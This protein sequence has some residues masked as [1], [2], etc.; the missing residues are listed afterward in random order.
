MK[1]LRSKYIF[2]NGVNEFEHYLYGIIDDSNLLTIV[3]EHGKD[4]HLVYNFRDNHGIWGALDEL[5][6]GHGEEISKDEYDK[7]VQKW[8]N[9]YNKEQP[10]YYDPINDSYFRVHNYITLKEMGRYD[11]NGVIYSYDGVQEPQYVRSQ[12]EFEKL[13]IKK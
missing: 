7:L 6:N 5:M 9:E 10:R 12:K 13:Y 4:P 8:I 1:V 2:D 11:C 3:D